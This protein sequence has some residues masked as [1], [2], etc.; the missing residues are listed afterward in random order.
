MKKLHALVLGLS[1]ALP[2]VAGA[3]WQWLDKNGRKEFSDRPPPADVPAANILKRPNS[4]KTPSTA[5]ASAP[6]AGASAPAVAT[7]AAAGNVPVLSGK[8]KELED[9]KKKAEAE[10]LAKKQA[11]EQKFAKAR[12]ENC[13]RAKK[14]KM[15]FDSGVR[16]ARTGADGQR[17]I[18][19]DAARKVE[20][21]RIESLISKE[22]QVL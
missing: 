9:K 6:A 22:C 8:D 17:E 11:E 7:N 12:A 15:A 1:L 10:E 3:Q 19:D 18:M 2:L 13:D 21:S 20:L 14:A 4:S 16:L 5:T